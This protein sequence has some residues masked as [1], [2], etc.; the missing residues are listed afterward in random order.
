MPL[1]IQMD[2]GEYIKNVV[3]KFLKKSKMMGLFQSLKHNVIWK[4]FVN[5]FAVPHW[6]PLCYFA[7]TGPHH[8]LLKLCAFIGSGH[9]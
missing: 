8:H 3:V 2:H 5:L 1:R 9:S 6:E 4:E 7:A